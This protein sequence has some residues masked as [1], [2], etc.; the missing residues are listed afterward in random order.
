[1][2][3]K[4]LIISLVA[5][6]FLYTSSSCT[7]TVITTVHDSTTKI[8]KDTTIRHDTTFRHDTVVVYSPKN[9]IIGIWVG[10][11][12]INSNPGFGNFYYAISIFQDHSMEVRSGGPNGVTWT[13]TGTWS[14]AADSTFTADTQATDPTEGGITEHLTAKYS[15]AN[16]TLIG[17]YQYTNSTLETGSFSLKRVGAQ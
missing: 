17:G 4:L 2:K 14:L 3:L 16:G 8:I 10:S 11:F 13:S 15:A 12:Y 5:L 1:M 9:P 7:K 6:G